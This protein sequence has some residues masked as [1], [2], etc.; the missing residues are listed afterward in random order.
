MKKNIQLTMLSFV[1]TTLIGCQKNE[2]TETSTEAKNDVQLQEKNKQHISLDTAQWVPSSEDF[3][4]VGE[5]SFD[6]DNVVRIFPIVS[7]SVENVRVSLGDYVQK[8]QVLA[9]IISTDITEYQRNFNV[10]KSNFE[11]A[12]KNFDRA[13]ELY[14]TKV[15]SE[16]DMAEAKKDYDIA[17]SDYNEKRQILKLY[18][19]S[20]KTLDAIYT[21]TAPRSGYI[22]ER[23][24]NEGLQIR[25]DNSSAMFTISD[26]KTV[27]VWAN[28]Y[29]SDLSKVRE[30]DN[31]VV[32]TIAYPDRILKGQITKIGTMLDPASRVIK[33][34]TELDNPD[35]LLKPEMFATITISPQ[36]KHKVLAIP[37]N[38]IIIENSRYWVMKETAPDRFSK[39]EITIGDAFR[40][41]TEVKQGLTAGDRIVN[42]G[43]LLVLTAYNLQ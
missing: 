22:V 17:L 34:R 5:I 35:G 12:S 15:I 43:S 30:G 14:E 19:S 29:E 36:T 21:V 20:E 23:N 18:G 2:A 41:L 31:V 38:S 1:L 11:T 4:V 37:T 42:G 13:K 7:G 27:W 10:A 32:T 40:N 25:T 3:N 8:G 28:V 24:I 33:V 39:V 16:R 26:L 9:Q 6:E